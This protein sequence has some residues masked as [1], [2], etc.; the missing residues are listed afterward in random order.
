[1]LP[2]AIMQKVYAYQNNSYFNDLKIGLVSMS[3]SSI[4][5]SLSGDY[6]LNGKV[7]PSGSLLSLTTDGTSILL[8]GTT[9]NQINLVPNSNSSFLIIT[10]GTVS[11]K[12]M[13]SF[14]IK[15]LNG[16]LLPINSIY[17]EDYLKGVVGYEMANNFPLEAL[18]AQTIAARNYALS[19]IGYEASKGYDFDDTASYQVYKGYNSSYQNVIN[20][21]NQTR[22]E[23]LLYNDKLVETLYSAWHGGVSEN[24][25]NVWGNTVPYL[26]SVSDPYESDA[27]PNG[28][29]IYSNAQVQAAL[30][31]KRYLSSTDIFESLDLS[32][33]TR[34][35]SGRVSSINIIYKDSAG[36]DQTKS[37]TKDNTRTFLGLP[38]NL[39]TVTY[40]SVNG[41]YTFSGKGN[42]HGLGMS[43][44]G[45]RNRAS[46]GQTYNE[47]LKFYYQGTYIQNLILKASL[48]T[49]TQNSSSLYLRNAISFN[50]SGINGNGYGYLFKYVVK[51]DSN[52]VFTQDYSSSTELNYTPLNSGNYTAEIYIKDNFSISDYDDMKVIPFSIYNPLNLVS[53]NKD[54]QNVFTGDTVTLSSIVNGGSGSG[55]Q[56]KYVVSRDGQTIALRNYDTNN[57]FSFNPNLPGN[58]EVYVYAVDPISKKEFDVTGKITFGVI[59]RAS[60]ASATVSGYLYEGKMVTLNSTSTVSDST[61]INYKYEIYNNES[62]L[63]SNSFSESSQFSFTPSNS[64]VYTIKIY[65]K[66]GL[67]SRSYDSIKQFDITISS[68]PLILST[69][70]LSY[71]MTNKDVALLQNALIK[72]G[73]PLSGATGYFGSQ[74]KDTVIS[75]QKSKGLTADGIVGNLTY[76]TL[77]DALIQKAGIKNLTF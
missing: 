45:A 1:M 66:D 70:P 63:T 15:V 5:I 10:S 49:I 57:S 72:L 51:N 64:G 47:I 13:G 31:S 67:S 60:I 21:V 71:G 12:Y 2:L 69:L 59:Q 17:I 18:K 35:P 50:A 43:Q 4:S 9:L 53:F 41:F 46:A 44:I 62:L 25:E 33:I 73:Y 76:K 74:T 16:K 11:N 52:I 24:S 23:V 6:A 3:A 34:F 65:E 30:V 36:V 22:G 20:A 58:Y 19:R 27:W 38:S 54:I 14:L 7:Y 26:R 42:G 32:S 40:D 56:Y 8:N 29:R 77:N 37:V 48:G 61:N 39:Y 28:N 75:F 68:K 55:V